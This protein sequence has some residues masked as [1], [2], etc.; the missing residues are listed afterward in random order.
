LAEITKDI[1]D[2]PEYFYC[3][4]LHCK[5][6]LKICIA[7]QNANNSRKGF[8]QMPFEDCLN[9]EQGKAI[10]DNG[11]GRRG[12]GK[13][14]RGKGRRNEKCELYSVCLDLAARKDWKTFNC[15]SC[16]HFTEG[17]EAVSEPVK[18]T[19]ICE[20]CGKKTTIKPTSPLC[21]S[22]MAIKS[23]EKRKKKAGQGMPRPEKASPRGDLELTINFKG[24]EAVLDEI[25]RLAE[26]EERLVD[27]QALYMLKM[28]LAEI[29]K[30]EQGPAMHRGE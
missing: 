13:P 12:N 22:C 5:L 20:E 9:C 25:R 14:R 29:G 1:L 23:N 19:R 27:K 16:P 18:N 3:E 28:Y 17:G 30:K 26:E 11:G 4:R 7:R 2:L 6:R 10:L 8:Q 24:R 21:A 15:E